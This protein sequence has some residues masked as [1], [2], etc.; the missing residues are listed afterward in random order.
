M[1]YNYYNIHYVVGVE[2]K[3]NKNN[4]ILLFKLKIKKF[5][6]YII[7]GMYFLGF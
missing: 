6:L 1:G 4:I 5:L 2:M 7:N 3:N